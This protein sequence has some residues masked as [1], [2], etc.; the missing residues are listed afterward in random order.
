MALFAW[1]WVEKR[2]L[3]GAC[4]K[5]C[6][7]N[8]VTTDNAQSFKSRKEW[9]LHLR[10]RRRSI[11]TPLTQKAAEQVADHLCADAFWDAEHIAL[12]LAND[13]ELDPSY[14]AQAAWRTG[15]QI[16][17]PVLKPSGMQFCEWRSTDSLRL[18]RY[19]IGEPQGQPAPINRLQVILLPTVGWTSM[20]FRLGMGGGYYDRFLA[21]EQ[22]QSA[23]RI[24][25]AY[26]CQCLDV[27]ESLR[28]NWDQPL[29][30]II[31]ENGLRRFGSPAAD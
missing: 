23:K 22:A 18:N 9:R 3:N 7:N 6:V 14:I 4:G 27:L 15:K 13:G 24:G 11:D 28:E 25:L 16:Y 17:L 20:G 31:T 1:A 30:A 5:A 12:Y 19:G 21:D 10:E 2:V 29:D 8:P 26:D